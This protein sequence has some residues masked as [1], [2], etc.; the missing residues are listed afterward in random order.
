VNW[1]QQRIRNEIGGAIAELQR[2][3][4]PDASRAMMITV[5][6]FVRLW[7]HVVAWAPA[8]IYA[9]F[10][11]HFSSETN[12][13]PMLTENVWDKALHAIEYAGLAMLVSYAWQSEG[14]GRGRTLVFAIV[15]TTLYAASDEFHQF[16]VPG[17]D[18]SVFD[19]TA[20]AI[21]GAAG[22]ALF[23]IATAKR[24]R[25]PFYTPRKKV[26]DSFSS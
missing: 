13:L 24:G 25:S 19:W 2:D 18:S 16:F 17:R 6:L 9:A 15:V 10:I 21:G 11:F 12:P 20:D 8:V 26:Y 23:A 4:R 22:A 5:T 7:R 3:V 1:F 14:I